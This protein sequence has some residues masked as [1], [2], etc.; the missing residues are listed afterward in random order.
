MSCLFVSGLAELKELVEHKKEVI[1]IFLERDMP[2]RYYCCIV[3]LI[4]L[5]SQLSK[6]E[7]MCMASVNSYCFSVASFLCSWIN[8]TI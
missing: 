3:W 1:L 5:R 4:S 2:V 7:S 8:R 6:P